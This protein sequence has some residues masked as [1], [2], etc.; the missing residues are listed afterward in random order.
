MFSLHLIWSLI[1]KF[2]IYLFI[3][4]F[5]DSQY[6]K[7]VIIRLGLL[8]QYYNGT[9]KVNQVNVS[10][11]QLSYKMKNISLILMEIQIR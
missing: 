7:Q 4:L 11:M 3:Y 1:C 8:N 5:Y 6:R 10:Q 2:M 9:N